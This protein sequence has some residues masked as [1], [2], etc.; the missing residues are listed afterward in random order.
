MNPETARA[1]VDSIQRRELGGL[2]IEKGLVRPLYDFK[3][4]LA[5]QTES[6]QRPALRSTRSWISLPLAGAHAHQD[7]QQWL[8]SALVPP[9][10]TGLVAGGGGAHRR[11][12]IHCRQLRRLDGHWICR[13]RVAG[14][15]HHLRCRCVRQWPRWGDSI[16][17]MDFDQ[18]INLSRYGSRP[19]RR[20][21]K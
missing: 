16:W 19:R 11:R 15:R 2:R 6:G 14:A 9:V 7:W 17:S 5:R 8:L 3:I 12:H 21:M 10:L 13:F 18:L 1:G 20:C 4:A